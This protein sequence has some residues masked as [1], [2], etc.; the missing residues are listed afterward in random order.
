MQPAVLEYLNRLS[1]VL[2]LSARVIEA[3]H[4]ID[5]R[6]RGDEHPGPPWSRAAEGAALRL[7]LYGELGERRSGAGARPPNHLSV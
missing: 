4:G 7:S 6:L 2:W 1:D 5:A 3:R